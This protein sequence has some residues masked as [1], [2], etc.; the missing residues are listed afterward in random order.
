MKFINPILT[1]LFVACFCACS[2]PNSSSSISQSED[3]KEELITVLNTINEAFQ[4][5]DVQTLGNMITED[6]VHTN[7]NA[8]S[9][10]KE[11]WLNYLQKR[12][13]EIKSGELEVLNYNMAE[14]EIV[15]HGKVAIVTGKVEVT[16]KRGEEIREN[17]YRITNIWVKENNSWKRAGFHDGKIL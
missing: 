4:K 2:S 8:P 7:G 16:N 13:Q 14:M 5:G 10:D 15:F 9:I 6:Y 11:T 3:I 1:L 17:A 12:T